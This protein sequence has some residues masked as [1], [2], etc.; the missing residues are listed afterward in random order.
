LGT[1]EEETYMEW[2]GIIGGLLALIIA[3]LF[4]I[5]LSIIYFVIALFV[6]NVA[7]DIV[8]DTPLGTDM[9]VLSAA[10]LTVGTMIAG[11]GIRRG[12]D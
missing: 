7:A 9:A 8:F 3:T 6:I 2:K 4:A 11:A 12:T 10:L 1:I 5:I